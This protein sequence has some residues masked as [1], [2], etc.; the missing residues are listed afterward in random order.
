[1]TQIGTFT[2]LK[3]LFSGRVQTLSLTAS[4]V[5]VPVHSETPQAPDYIIRL[6]DSGGLEVGAGWKKSGERAGDYITIQLDDPSFMAPLR[7]NLFRQDNDHRVW[8]LVWNRQG[9][10]DETV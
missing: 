8:I 4:V 7:A 5:L 1:M 2:R 6:S 3:G 9:R 10:R